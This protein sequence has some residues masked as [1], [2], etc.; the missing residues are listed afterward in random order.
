MDRMPHRPRAPDQQTGSQAGLSLTRF[1]LGQDQGAAATAERAGGF[2]DAELDL[3][4]HSRR[5]P[6][7]RG[8]RRRVRRAL[9]LALALALALTRALTLVLTPSLTL[10]LT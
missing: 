8:A 10:T 6:H 9:S 7:G 1:C 2:G 4:P 5:R 3:G